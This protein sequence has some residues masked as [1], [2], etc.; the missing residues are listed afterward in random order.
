VPAASCV[1]AAGRRR[2][3]PERGHGAEQWARVSAKATW[4]AASPDARASTSPAGTPPVATIAFGAPMAAPGQCGVRRSR[5]AGRRRAR[6]RCAVRE[7]LPEERSGASVETGRV[8]AMQSAGR[9]QGRRRLASGLAATGPFTLAGAETFTFAGAGPFT[10]AGA[11]LAVASCGDVEAWAGADLGSGAGVTGVGATVRPRRRFA[12][13][14]HPSRSLL[15]QR[16][17]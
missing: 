11:R 1:Q 2:T 7:P 6:R 15:V 5:C 17:Q 4:D 16:T 3:V 8:S 13:A 12:A 14:S 9:I 10:L